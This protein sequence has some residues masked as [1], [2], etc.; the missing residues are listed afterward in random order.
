MNLSTTEPQRIAACGRR[1]RRAALTAAL[2]V[3]VLGLA[4]AA[5]APTARAEEADT[6][7]S[8]SP[9]TLKKFVI[10]SRHGVRA[11]IPKKSELETWTTSLWPTW[12]C[13][14]H[15][16][17]SGELTPAGWA[18][19]EQMGTSYRGYLSSL[20]PEQCPKPDELYFWADVT[21][22]R[23]RDTGLALLHGFRPACEVEQYFHTQPAS[24]Q[25][26]HSVNRTA[27]NLDP[28]RAQRAI[29]AGAEGS[30][31]NV[32]QGLQA[33]LAQAQDVLQCCQK[34]CQ[35]AWE[36]TCQVGLP[37]PS[38]QCKLN[39]DLPSC[40]VTRPP[41]GT[42]AQVQLGGALRVASTFAEILLLEYANGFPDKDV[43]WGRIKPQPPTAKAMRPLFRLHT[44][45]FALEQ[46]TPYVAALQGSMLL[47]RILLALQ[48]KNDQGA[49]EAL[50][51]EAPPA[52]KF[53]AYVG[54]DT[55]IANV[56]GMLGLHWD[57]PPWQEA[58][59]QQD[60]IPPAGALAFELHEAGGK[61]NV[62][63]AY[64][65]QYLDD[66]RGFALDPSKR[67][68]RTVRVP[69]SV[70]GCSTQDPG[71]PCPL[72]R[73]ETLVKEKLDPDCSQ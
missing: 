62:H 73:F 39:Q 5:L 59:Y 19:A 65:A 4:S 21:D 1:P 53:V 61:R 6:L 58:G 8:P 15:E 16:C 41:S 36:R 13:G 42:P 27:C 32:A 64:M 69:V 70:P 18:L 14:N 17:G 40:L 29:I 63:V 48:G 20:L 47:R 28:V 30:L 66:M 9:S 22:E 24:D 3:L 25:I 51:G 55:N 52:A 2:W 35:V 67:P 71:F 7:A 43:G 72:D 68:L 56:G 45:A 37:R 33:E 44:K 11:P 38:N 31:V 57:S 60:Q 26:F 10:L 50:P 34:L 54:H 49:A 23:T 12:T 46:R